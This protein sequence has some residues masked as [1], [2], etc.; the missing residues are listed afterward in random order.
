[1]LTWLL[2]LA[3][4]TSNVVLAAHE[5]EGE[6]CN[7][8]SACAGL[9][10]LHYRNAMPCPWAVYTCSEGCEARLGSARHE[11]CAAVLKRSHNCCMAEMR[12][13]VMA[14]S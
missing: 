2:H 8:C 9:V 1:M 3:Q 14:Q 12:S 11:I 13:P 4:G 5:A 7:P 10:N 6:P